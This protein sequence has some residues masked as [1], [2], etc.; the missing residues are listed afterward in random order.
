[1]RRY[2]VKYY[3]YKYINLVAIMHVCIS[4]SLYIVMIDMT[5]A[6]R[7]YLQLTAAPVDTQICMYLMGPWPES[8][9]KVC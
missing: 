2:L 7:I 9:L 4:L 1:M 8:G 5:K 3:Y 6:S